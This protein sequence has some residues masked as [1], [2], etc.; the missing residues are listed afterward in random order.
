MVFCC[1]QLEMATWTQLGIHRKAI[2]V[3][4]VLGIYDPLQ[5]LL[6][7]MVK[8]GFLHEKYGDMFIFDDDPVRLLDRVLAAEPPPGVVAWKHTIT[9]EMKVA[10]T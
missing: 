1:N 2:G 10:L 9:G 5:Q 4:N 8:N 7:S 3:L 6:Q